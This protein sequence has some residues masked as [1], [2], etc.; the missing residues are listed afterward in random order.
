M[1]AYVTTF[2]SFKGGVGRTTL[3][4][5][6][7]YVLAERGERVLVWDLDLEAP[8]VHYFPGLEPP[9]QLWQSGF[10]EWLGDT[11]P[12]PSPEPTVAWPSEAW[13]NT[14]GDRVYAAP[15]ET[16]RTIF[17]LPALGTYGN[18][19][20]AY[21]GVDWH[22]LFVERPEHGLHLLNRVRDELIARF[23][24]TFLLIDSRTGISD[25]GGFLTGLVPDC[26]VLVGNYSAQ[27]TQ[28]LR[29]VYLALDRFATERVTAEPYRHRKL[30]RVLV[31]SPVPVSPRAREQGR[32]RWSSGFSGVAPR[33]LIEIPLVENLLYAEDVL[34]RTAPSSDAARA[35]RTVAERLIEL[36]ASYVRSEPVDRPGGDDERDQLANVERLLRLLGFKTTRSDGDELVAHERTPLGERTYLVKYLAGTART[37]PALRDEL[38]HRRGRL[39]SGQDQPLLIVDA[40]GDDLRRA[41]EAASI[42][43]RTT[44][45]LEDQLVDLRAYV[46]SLRRM[47]EDSELARTYVAPSVVTH[48]Q[49]T[50]ALSLAMSWATGNGPHL[51]VLVGDDGSGKT[52]FVQRLAYEL[53]TQVDIDASIPVP[54][55]IDLVHAATTSTLAS[56]LQEHLQR[57]IG[58]HGN[59]EAILHLY[60]AGRIVLLCD[61]L[62]DLPGLRGI[63]DR[64]RWLA[65]STTSPGDTA[66]AHRM[67]VTVRANALD[68]ASVASEMLNPQIATLAPFSHEQIVTFLTNRLGFPAANEPYDQ[69]VC[70]PGLLQLASRP[71]LLALIA[72]GLGGVGP[73]EHATAAMLYDRHVQHWIEREAP[74]S[75]LPPLQRV[76]IIE[77]MAAELWQRRARRLA[78]AS[79][80]AAVHD[81][82]PSDLT[83]SQL[84]P[85]LRGAPFLVR[86]EDEGYGFSRRAFLEYFVAR[87]LAR[88]ARAGADTLRDALAT[89]TLTPSCIALLIEIVADA[90]EARSTIQ[91][92]AAG[93]YVPETWENA[94]KIAVA[95]SAGAAGR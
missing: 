8:G 50:D 24:P 74:G 68:D 41:A 29:G 7:A 89:D 16:R 75:V 11:P 38:D 14:L 86:S 90:P 93:P 58:W 5:N 78:G 73:L 31:A 47:F 9:E 56:L 34:V 22:A 91:A 71:M 6:A 63:G 19:G 42:T 84:D 85:E 83:V 81:T 67:L 20:S 51:L 69:I 76:R 23:E 30:E 88:C 54:V 64:L 35:Y 1:T 60:R 70:T 59:P 4:V 45:E 10:L 25:L 13:L 36:R 32:A 79:L 95:L 44:G 62:E 18:L 26:T 53:A 40:A 80:L 48:G 17:V 12:C 57:A 77:R 27:S 92:I 94:N 43:L 52:S 87:H 37:N 21:A 15:G 66:T 49:T 2:Y 72:D 65:H 33:T 28:G 39:G 55:L 61:G 82:V 46:A 3:L